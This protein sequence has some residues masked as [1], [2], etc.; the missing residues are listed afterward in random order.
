MQRRPQAVARGVVEVGQAGRRTLRDE[1]RLERPGRP[2]RHDDQ[3]VVVLDDDPLA[4]RLLVDV[5]EQQAA[6]GRLEVARAGRHPRA[7]P[8]R[9]APCRP[10]SG[11]AD[12]G[13]RRPSPRPGS[14]TPGPSGT[15]AELGRSGPPTGRRSRGRRRRPSGERQVVARREADDPAGAALALRAEQPGLERRV[16]RVRPERREVVGEDE[17]VGVGRVDVAIGAVLPGHR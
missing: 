5:V 10:R 15:A 8:R 1:Q 9:A 12:A 6:A 2:E 7:R 3:P 16:G 14:R 13:W 11:R 17:R 4:A